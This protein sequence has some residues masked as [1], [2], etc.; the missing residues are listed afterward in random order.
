M[1]D[2]Y[3]NTTNKLISNENLTAEELESALSALLAGEW[4]HVQAAAF[5]TAMCIK[6]VTSEEVVSAASYLMKIRNVID[7]PDE[8][9]ILDTA[10]TGGDGKGTFN[11]S[12]ASAFVAA[13]SGVKVAKHGNRAMSG[14]CGSSDILTELGANL[15]LDPEKTKECFLQTGICF[16]S[17]PAHHPALKE[18]APVRSQLGFRT[19]F[20]LLGPLVN[21]ANVGCRMAGIYDPNWVVPY[22]NAFKALKAKR[23]LV[24]HADGMDE[25]SISGESTYAVLDD[26]QEIS[27]HTIS[28]KDL[29]I[30]DYPLSTIIVKDRS[31][32]VAMFNDA[33]DGKN[34][35]ATTAI[36]LNGG[37]AIFTAGKV[38]SIKE[39]YEMAEDAIKSNKVRE[40][41]NEF[42]KVTNSL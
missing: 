30:K 20:N 42:I 21:P 33:V 17:A 29:G 36:C 25:F 26:K 13:A 39:G 4:D 28:P 24:V 5:L 11:I 10:G 1:T 15:N 7:L 6:G 3:I 16:M 35:A 18:V 14:T 31:E 2:I 32:A 40:K 8:K 12:T 27:T 34:E 9:N 23:A 38:A 19:M 41:L 37:A 22:A